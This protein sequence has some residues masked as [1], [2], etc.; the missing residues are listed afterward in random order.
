MLHDL[1]VVEH[2]RVVKDDFHDCLELSKG[3]N[4]GLERLTRLPLGAVAFTLVGRFRIA[5]A[6]LTG[7]ERLLNADVEKERDLHEVEELVEP[8]RHE[9]PVPLLLKE[10]D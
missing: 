8:D 9:E 5:S 2:V 10:L 3:V 4:D 7:H 1:P 6:W